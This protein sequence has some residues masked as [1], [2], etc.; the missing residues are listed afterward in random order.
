MPQAARSGVMARGGRTRRCEHVADERAIG[1][2]M[3]VHSVRGKGE[4]RLVGRLRG[5]NVDQNKK[6]TL[7]QPSPASG[8]G[9]RRAEK[10]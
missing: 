4:H 8:R 2:N 3:V 1:A 9:L 7:T 5:I 10:K 6:K